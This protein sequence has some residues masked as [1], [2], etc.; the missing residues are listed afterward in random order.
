MTKYLLSICLLTLAACGPL[1]LGS[2]TPL[3]SDSGNST[4]GASNPNS[5]QALDI[6]DRNCTSC[7]GSTSGSGNVYGLQSVNH[8]VQAGLIVPG[9]PSNSLLYNEI[10]TGSMPP[11]GPLSAAEQS[12]I[13][14]WI[15][16]ANSS[17]GSTPVT[18]TPTPQPTP[19]PAPTPVP[20][21][22][23]TPAASFAYI[24]KTILGPKCTACHAGTSGSAGYS[25]DTYTRTM[26]S[27]NTNSPTSS[28]LYTITHSGQMP[29]RASQRLN[30][31]QENLILQWIQEGAK[32]N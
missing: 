13:Y 12:A 27:V 1:Q 31:E 26:K 29:P 14:Q 23:P 22:A 19:T 18:P 30:S 32:N 11:G 3:T 25:F 2:G 9:S 24:E 17:T 7:H 15:L 5:A 6:L 21:P 20:S 10:S 4:L 28:K 8:M 16:S